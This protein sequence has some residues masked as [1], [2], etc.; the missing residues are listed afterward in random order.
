MLYFHIKLLKVLSKEME[1]KFGKLASTDPFLCVPQF[2]L[3]NFTTDLFT[4]DYL[5][6]LSCKFISSSPHFPNVYWTAQVSAESRSF[7]FNCGRR[8]YELF[9]FFISCHQVIS[10]V[11]EISWRAFTSKYCFSKLMKMYTNYGLV[12][13]VRSL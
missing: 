11:D 3:C 5:L 13:F 2:F 1:D 4:I 10:V 7:L 9:M 12:I 6:T 8:T